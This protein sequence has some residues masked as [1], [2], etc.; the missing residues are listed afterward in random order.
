MRP[1]WLFA[2]GMGRIDYE[3]LPH[4]KYLCGRIQ[5]TEL[6]FGNEH[7]LYWQVLRQ[8]DTARVIREEGSSRKCLHK[9]QL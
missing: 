1:H 5:G 3:S 6:R 8:F 9:T 2:L 7:H 4:Y